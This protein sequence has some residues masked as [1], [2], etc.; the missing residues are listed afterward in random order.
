MNLGQS[1]DTFLIYTM[2]KKNKKPKLSRREKLL[3]Y[4]DE[5]GKDNWCM[6]LDFLPNGKEELPPHKRKPIAQV[7]G[8]EK[9]SLLEIVPRENITFSTRQKLF[10]GEG[11][12]REVDHI[13]RKIK[14]EWLT[15]LAKT[16]M[17]PIVIKIIKSN[18]EKYIKFFN[19]PPAV[20]LNRN[21]LDSFPEISKAN[22]NKI[23]K[24]LKTERF[25]C[26]RDVEK[27]GAVD[28]I[29]EIVANQIIREISRQAEFYIFITPVIKK[30]RR[31][32]L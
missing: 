6:V 12:R 16:E 19:N 11:T 26:L 31:N 20:S 10:I 15:S 1:N 2:A 17:S 24:A 30:G 14:F 3:K 8:W 13:E 27:A 28:N 21:I 9:F 25:T 32:Q 7:I 22:R 23:L 18:E 5:Q 4:L 29:Y